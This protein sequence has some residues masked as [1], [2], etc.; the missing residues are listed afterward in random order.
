[1]DS[2]PG[3]RSE[4]GSARGHFHAVHDHGAAYDT[5]VDTSTGTPAELARIVL[6]RQQFAGKAMPS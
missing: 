1:M 4:P 6:R 5:I 3:I 2:T